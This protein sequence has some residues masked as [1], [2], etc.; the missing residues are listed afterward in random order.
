MSLMLKKEPRTRIM[1]QNRGQGSRG[2]GFKRKT[3]KWNFRT[4]ALEP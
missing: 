3:K 1:G 2:H 4:K